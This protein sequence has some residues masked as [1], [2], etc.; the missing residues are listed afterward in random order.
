MEAAKA[1]LRGK[2]IKEKISKLMNLISN[3]NRKRRASNLKVRRD[4]TNIRKVNEIQN[5]KNRKNIYENWFFS[6][7]TKFTSL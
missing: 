6:R 3:F 7:S 2:Y 1:A 4:S 5:R